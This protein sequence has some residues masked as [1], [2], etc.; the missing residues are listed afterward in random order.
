[1]L[2]D[3][4]IEKNINTKLKVLAGSENKKL[5]VT[6]IFSGVNVSL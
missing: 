5:K 6:L 3:Y 1:M 4:L 2:P